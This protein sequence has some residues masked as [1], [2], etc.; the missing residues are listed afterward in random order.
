MSNVLRRFAMIDEAEKRGDI[1]A[2]KTT[3][4]VFTVLY[5]THSL[6]CLMC[7]LTVSLDCLTYA[8]T[9]LYVHLLS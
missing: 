5:A 6:D 7:A 9:V 1:T 8:L 4:V 3:L 2:G